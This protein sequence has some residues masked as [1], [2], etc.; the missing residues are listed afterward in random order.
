MYPLAKKIAVLTQKINLR[1][2]QTANGSPQI[3]PI[4][5]LIQSEKL[6]SLSQEV[7]QA[8]H[9]NST[10]LQDIVSIFK[11]EI[12]LGLKNEFSSLKMLPRYVT[13][14]NSSEIKANQSI[15]ALD[16]GGTNVRLLKINFDQIG[17]PKIEFNKS[18]PIPKSIISSTKSEILFSWIAD[19]IKKALQETG[20]INQ[21]TCLSFPACSLGFTFSFRYEQQA[22]NKAI[23]IKWS[24]GFQATDLIGQDPCDI[25][26]QELEKKGIINM[27]IKAIISDTIAT[28]L[29][30]SLIDPN[31]DAGMIIGTG[32]GLCLNI[33]TTMIQKPMLPYTNNEMAMVVGPGDFD[34]K[35]AGYYTRFDE[36]TDQASETPGDKWT[37]KM[38][39]GKYLG[40]ILRVMLNE[41]LDKQILTKDSIST[42]LMMKIANLDSIPAKTKLNQLFTDYHV[43]IKVQTDYDAQ[44]IHVLALL[45]QNRSAQ[46][47]ATEIVGAIRLIDPKG[48]HHHTVAMDGSL[49]EKNPLYQKKL[50]ETI[51][52]L[53]SN[54]IQIKFMKDSSGIGA[55]IAA[56]L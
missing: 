25:L 51:A 21:A 41:T 12:K 50:N 48:I 42:E 56:C 15:F 33:P 7:S 55:A 44:L 38:V 5:T 13:K 29:T 37:E 35:K 46:L 19:Q 23:F 32:N 30:G 9:L 16:F 2:P 10:Q 26:A 39:S 8:L 27:P 3:I 20:N 43:P 28:F 6:T 24:K 47:A 34:I 36:K 40:E 45:I 49:F 54:N 14:I 4:S 52:T 22:L 17:K 53:K 1:A 11:K 18:F 31:C